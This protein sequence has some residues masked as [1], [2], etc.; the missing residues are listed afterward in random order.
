M[1]K[2]Y[3][4][5]HPIILGL[6]GKAG[7]GKT[8]AAEALC[9]KASMEKVSNG[10]IWE[11][12]FH[13]LPLY[14]LASIKRNIK[15]SNERSRKLYSIHEVLFEIY[16]KTSLGGIPKY[17][18]FVE[19]VKQ[20]YDLP[21]EE[22]GIKPRTF[23]QKS[24]DICRDGYTECLCHWVVMKSVELYRKNSYS[25]SKEDTDNDTPI[26]VIISDVRFMNE[27]QSIL[28]QP[29]GIVITYDASNSIL[30]DRLF[31]RDGIFMTDEQ[32]NHSSEQQID[33]VKN[34]STYII[35]TDNLSIESQ[36]KETLKLVKQHIEN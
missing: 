7:S 30:Q 8:S 22:Q 26:C 11:H 2:K 1:A 6:A 33:L 20:I 21:V 16:G 13:A 34:V 19:K 9:P 24:G 10:I 29:N 12:I 5:D 3:S 15:G 36:A 32:L 4:K 25:I 28:K 31:K 27:A 23:L 35:N 17:E 18:D 14:E